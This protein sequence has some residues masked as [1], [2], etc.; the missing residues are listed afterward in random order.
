MTVGHVAFPV[1]IAAV[2][3]LVI[4]LPVLILPVDIPVW[5]GRRFLADQAWAWRL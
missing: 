4:G 3:G 1:A 2:I 5:F